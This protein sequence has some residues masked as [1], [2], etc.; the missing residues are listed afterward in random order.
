MAAPSLD[1]NVA[2]FAARAVRYQ[3]L[4]PAGNGQAERYA[5][6]LD[7]RITNTGTSPVTVRT[8]T[9]GFPT[10]P[11]L[12]GKVID[13]WTPATQ[14]DPEHKGL[15]I[16]VGQQGAPKDFT[17]AN[18]LVLNTTPPNQ[19]L[20][21][22]AADGFSEP[23][24][25]TR[26]L[27][28][29]KQSFR[30]F[31]RP[32]EL[33]RGE[34]WLGEGGSHCCGPQL[35]AYDLGCIGYDKQTKT[36]SELKPGAAQGLNASYRIWGKPIY[37]VAD[38]I[39]EEKLDG[40]VTNT[41]GTT[42]PNA[43]SSGNHFLIQHGDALVYYSHMQSGS[44][45][46]FE[47]GDKVTEGD[48]LGRVGNSGNSFAPHLHVHTVDE[49]TWLLRP[50]T[51]HDTVMAKSHP[52]RP[53]QAQWQAADDRAIPF[54]RTMIYPSEVPPAD[55]AEWSNWGS[56]GGVATSA[57]AVASWTDRRLD[58]FVRGTDNALYHKWFDGSTW[59]GW[60]GLGGTLTSA[61]AAV[62]WGSNRIDVFVRG[63]DNALYHKWWDGSKW[64]NWEGLGG[65]LQFAPA[66]CSRRPNHLDVFAAWTD[67]SL[68][69]R[70]W[71]GSKWTQ[72]ENLGGVL[73]NSPS[74]VSWGENRIDVFA[75]G[76]D[77]KLYQ[78]WWDGSSWQG[79]AGHGAD[80]KFAPAVS[81]R[82][83]NHLDVYTVAADN[84]LWHRLWTGSKWSHW[85]NLGGFLT[86]APAA[87]SWDEDRIDVFARGTDNAIYQTLWRP[88]D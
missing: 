50:F 53:G 30:W 3:P 29:A 4:A 66:V 65:E 48:F 9:V 76:T 22:I 87:V 49:D 59:R 1:L 60:E 15:T 28:R 25:F 52:A 55:G 6:C 80:S 26:P 40:I 54:Q 62:S 8:L 83:P 74:A 42:N 39:V 37:A 2:P 61:P 78:R 45:A 56:L 86:E 24:T 69:H 77:G 33:A 70:I 73:S 82:R 44:L 19:V 38:G 27:G 71:T 46:A 14:T 21:S 35:F 58:V 20:F 79:W 18:T 10:A 32:H 64:H 84:T 5:L 11:G 57:P 75:P 7:V 41:V 51:F 85:E 72:W 36:W 63:T 16:P 47:V 31:G 12:P 34:Y 43:H 13:L 23:A 88:E 68:R 17:Q 81:S 67:G